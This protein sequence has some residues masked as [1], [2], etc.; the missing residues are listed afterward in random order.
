MLKNS[1]KILL[2]GYLVFFTQNMAKAQTSSFDAEFRPRTEFRQG[3]QKPLTDLDSTQSALIT[4]QR[5]RFNADFK[6]KVV[7]ARISL[8]DSRIWG[9]SNTKTNDSKIELF[10]GWAEYL[11]TTGLSV[12]VGRQVLKYDDQRLL[13]ASNWSNTGISHDA[14]VFK[15]KDPFMQA[16]L[17]LAYNNSTDA[18]YNANYAYCTKVY[19][20]MGYGYVSKDLYAGLNL[21]LI[22]IV[23]GFQRA[24][25]YYN[26]LYPRATM[27]GNLLFQSDSS[28]LA[29]T[30]T[31]Y[32]QT[33]NDPNVTYNTNHSA[34]LNAHFFA[35]KVQYKV[36]APLSVNV[37]LD[38]YSGTS[39]LIN[40]SNKTST[41]KT[42]NKLY[43]SN[44]TFNGFMEYFSTVPAA[45]LA[46]YYGGATC[47]VSPRLSVDAAFHVFRL[48]ESAK[49]QK[50]STTALVDMSR[51]M[52]SELDLTC[53][54]SVCKEVALQ[55][56]Y[57]H[58]FNSGSTKNY[59]KMASDAS[60]QS[61]QWA[62]VMLTIKSLFY[63]TP[64]PL[65][66]DK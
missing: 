45:G 40:G 60:I 48:A 4:Y 31:G 59:F 32:F 29:F 62:Y 26:T 36:I 65:P 11:M 3:F 19:K 7:N 49:Y 8:Q 47:K 34:K 21:S 33:G 58:Y 53:N 63:K 50:S 46:D 20:T 22:G 38:Y 35:A 12:Q 25:P 17:G 6:G 57:S 51:D 30:L 1:F 54:Y 41:S 39:G 64:A 44:H 14:V 66:T 13:A 28:N 55:A 43:G 42:F 2:M 15:L 27:G 18:L 61:Q 16:H 56:G 5:T 9:G 24:K 10:E 37:G 52:G 23:E